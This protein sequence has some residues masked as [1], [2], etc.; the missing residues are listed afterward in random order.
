MHCSLNLDSPM[1]KAVSILN[2]AYVDNLGR[3]GLKQYAVMKDFN[4]HE[5]L[6]ESRRPASW[7]G[8]E[9]MDSF[10][11]YLVKGKY[12]AELDAYTID[13]GKVDRPSTLLQRSL[14]AYYNPDQRVLQNIHKRLKVFDE[15]FSSSIYDLYVV[16]M[17]EEHPDAVMVIDITVIGLGGIHVEAVMA[18][19][20]TGTFC[21][22]FV[23]D[24][25]RRMEEI[26]IDDFQGYDL[27]FKINFKALTASLEEV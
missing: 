27:E 8:G 7:E 11:E 9:I 13:F 3:Q 16:P 18:A 15:S 12:L 5:V 20:G 26:L 2:V 24:F 19:Y 4:Y 17:D 21:Q 23:K 10:I 1:L 14:K 6:L 25:N 22:E